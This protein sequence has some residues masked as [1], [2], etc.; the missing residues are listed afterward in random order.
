MASIALPRLSAPS[1]SLSAGASAHLDLEGKIGASLSAGLDVSLEASINADLLLT[2][3]LAADFNVFNTDDPTL[4]TL[5][6]AVPSPPAVPVVPE[7]YVP[8]ADTPGDKLTRE[9]ENFAVATLR[10]QM[11]T[12]HS[13]EVKAGDATT[14]VAWVPRV[15]RWEVGA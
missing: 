12:D 11:L 5:V 2:G 6:A 1:L 15:E 9:R 3:N 7:H 8:I 10:E 13:E 14:S 4:V